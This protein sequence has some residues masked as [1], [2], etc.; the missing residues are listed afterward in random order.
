MLM[1]L[2]VS[3][4]ENMFWHHHYKNGKPISLACILDQVYAATME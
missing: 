4:H 3:V 2:K 1:F